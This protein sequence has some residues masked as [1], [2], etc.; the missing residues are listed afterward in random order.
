M[1]GT[2]GHVAVATYADRLAADT[3][4][5]RLKV[6]SVPAGTQVWTMASPVAALA[7]DHGQT[8]RLAPHYLVVEA[9]A[10]VLMPQSRPVSAGVRA[11]LV[12]RLT[13]ALGHGFLLELD[14]RLP[15]CA[16][17]VTVLTDAKA[18]EA[19]RVALSAAEHLV[20]HELSPP[21]FL[22]RRR[23]W[24]GASDTPSRAMSA[25]SDTGPL[26]P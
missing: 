22:L 17:A 2:R 10:A 13:R 11:A 26:A 1:N 6:A 25:T 23:P 21:G 8:S 12:A 3:D 5:A 19:V 7:S 18:A 9:L 16:A 24:R 15:D 14:Q 4:L 20:D